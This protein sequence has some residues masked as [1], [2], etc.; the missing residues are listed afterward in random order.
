MKWRLVGMK[1]VV[2]IRG[3]DVDGQVRLFCE[4]TFG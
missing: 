4:D 1:A 2:V 3:Q